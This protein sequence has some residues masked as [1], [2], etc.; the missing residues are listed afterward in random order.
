MSKRNYL[1]KKAKKDRFIIDNMNETHI[2][3]FLER[4]L[5]EAIEK[6]GD[7]ESLYT[8]DL[9]V[10]S[11]MKGLRISVSIPNFS[12]ICHEAKTIDEHID[13]AAFVQKIKL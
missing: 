11:Y 2:Q 3:A 13:F 9:G 7:G 5:K 12:S 4:K 1:L 6:I 10:R 8:I